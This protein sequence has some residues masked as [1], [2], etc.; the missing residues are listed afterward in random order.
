MNDKDTNSAADA[1]CAWIKTVVIGENI[2]PFAA[3]A[4]QNMRVTVCPSSNMDDFLDGLALE[5]ADLLQLGADQVSTTILVTTHLFKDFDDYLD[6]LLFVET[7]LEQLNLSNEIQVASFHP[8]YVFE[9]AVIDDVANWTNRSPYPMFHFLRT[10]D[11]AEAI[12]NHPDV[13]GIPQRNIEHFRGL[14]LAKI[15]QMLQTC[16]WDATSQ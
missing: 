3:N 7:T 1:T 4:Y 11:V 13:D 14:G 5:L 10:A 6:G 2:C 15:K 9:G 8:H 16:Y 12:D